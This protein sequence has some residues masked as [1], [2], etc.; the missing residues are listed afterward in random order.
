MAVRHKTSNRYD[1][2]LGRNTMAIKSVTYWSQMTFCALTSALAQ[3]FRLSS[4]KAAS[5]P[6]A[7]FLKAMD[8]AAAEKSI[9]E[10]KPRPVVS[11]TFPPLPYNYHR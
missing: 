9:E 8:M 2:N 7:L 5:L 10:R 11:L 6:R 4:D 1:A 3:N